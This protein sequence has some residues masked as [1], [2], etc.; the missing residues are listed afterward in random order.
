[1]IRRNFRFSNDGKTSLFVR[2]CEP[3]HRSAERTV[4]VVH[5][6]GEHGG[7]YRHVAQR[8]TDENFNVLIADHRGHGQSDGLRNYVSSFSHFVD[9]LHRLFD[10]EN[11]EPETT[12]MLAHSMGGLMAIRFLQSGSP[13]IN[14]LC[15]SSPCLR[16]SVRIAKLKYAAGKLCSVVVPK[17]RFSTSVDPKLTTRNQEVLKRRLTDPLMIPFV[18]AGGFF[19]MLSAMDQA[20]QETERITVP[21]L[22]LQ[23]GADAVVD[24]DAPEEFFALCSNADVEVERLPGQYHEVL[25][26]PERDETLDLITSWLGAAETPAFRNT[27]PFN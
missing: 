14:S 1:M 24:P 19:Q 7:R 8:L 3:D 18:T 11:L 5:G 9:D 4:V 6:L 20:W 2:F 13:R 26:E 23:G 17:K 12:S 27:I 16:L 15:L 21:I 22:V 25:N 10:S